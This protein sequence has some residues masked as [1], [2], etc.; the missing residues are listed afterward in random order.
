MHHSIVG[1][2]TETYQ[3]TRSNIIPPCVCV[4]FAAFSDKVDPPALGNEETFRVYTDKRLGLWWAIAVGEAMVPAF[5][6]LEKADR[7]TAHRAAYDLAVWGE[8]TNNVSTPF[9]LLEAGAVSDTS[10]R[11]K[12]LDIAD[13]SL[14]KKARQRGVYSLAGLVKQYLDID[15]ED[16]KRGED[17]WQLNYHAL[18]GVLLGDWP[19]E[20]IDYAAL[21][22]VWALLV[23]HCQAMQDGYSSST[24]TRFIDHTGTVTDEV[25]QARAAFVLHLMASHGPRLDAERVEQTLA[26]W[27]HLYRAGLV[28]GKSAGFLRPNGS[29]DMKALR[30]LVQKDYESRGEP[31][32]RTEKG[33]VQTSR[34]VLSMCRH[35]DLRAWAEADEY[36]N[37]I[38]KYGETLRNAVGAPLCSRPNVLVATGRTSWSDPP[39]QGP[40]RKGGYREC[41]I[42]PAG[43][44]YVSIDYDQIELLALASFLERNDFGSEMADR[45][46]KGLD[47]HLDMA[48]ALMEAF[49][50]SAPNGSAWSYELADECKR[51]EHG[52]D[53]KKLVKLHRTMA[54][55][56]NFGLPGGLGTESFKTYLFTL[57]GMELGIDEATKIRNLYRE[58]NPAVVSYFDWVGAQT[59]FGEFTSIM[60]VSGRLRGGLGY[61]DGCNT[62]FQAPV[63]DGIKA[64]A[65]RIAKAMYT[66]PS[67][68][69][70]GSR[71]WLLL[72]DELMLDVP[73]YRLTEAA[74]E[75]AKIMRET[76]AQYVPGLYPGAEP[77]AMLRWY[78]EAE[79]VRGPHGE[80]LPW[81]PT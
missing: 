19:Q 37:Y 57:F 33:A 34:S 26:N 73:L 75:A 41:H 51:G 27:E 47:L 44:A 11:Q 42:P 70:Y 10:I 13:G 5:A 24:N 9:D 38:V 35:P 31:V 25:Q 77:A 45:I 63:S 46:R 80:L 61:C 50:H 22:A 8:H 30:E 58:R 76:M 16:W 20:A 72:H 81:E 39:L 49:G 54:K 79:P 53:F 15:L 7:L 65:W 23:W 55:G 40:P 28:A 12:L 68:P 62:H 43:H 18:D 17:R 32:P 2:D 21:D 67:S 48:V 71:M 74:D 4:T 60:P 66:Q 56:A 14:Q 6:W 59:E 36:R 52:D 1:F 69:L 64:A 3:T 78:K 29:R